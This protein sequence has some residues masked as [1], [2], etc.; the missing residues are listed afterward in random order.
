MSALSFGSLR[1]SSDEEKFRT[2]GCFAPTSDHVDSPASGFFPIILVRGFVQSI[3]DPLPQVA[4]GLEAGG[5]GEGGV[6]RASR[7]QAE[8]GVGPQ[9][10]SRR[11]RQGGAEAISAKALKISAAADR[12]SHRPRLRDPGIHDIDD[13][14]QQGHV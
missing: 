2:E 9:V 6:V 5:G 12:L 11:Y 14:A 7:A 4:I 8:D 10:I 1:F 13:K 3:S